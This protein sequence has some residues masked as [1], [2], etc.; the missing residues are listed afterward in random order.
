VNLLFIAGFVVASFPAL[1]LGVNNG[2][3]LLGV[4]VMAFSA[5]KILAGRKS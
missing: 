2:V 5:V 1:F 4:M 3:T